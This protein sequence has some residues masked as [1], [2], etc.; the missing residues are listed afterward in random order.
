MYRNEGGIMVQS[1]YAGYNIHKQYNVIRRNNI[2]H[3]KDVGIYVESSIM[4][5]FEENN[6]MH[7]K[8]DAWFWY[9]SVF[10]TDH[11]RD[12]PLHPCH[13]VWH[14]NYWSDWSHRAP[15]PIKG[16]VDIFIFLFDRWFYGF[17]L[18]C[19]NFDFHPAMEPYEF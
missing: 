6:L 14:A 17:S 18:P 2:S 8:V 9:Q 4:N 7:N 13:N 10:D 5:V 12:F 16:I 11:W 1:S 15:K 3:N 19:Y